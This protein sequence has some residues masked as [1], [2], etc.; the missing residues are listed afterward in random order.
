MKS[1]FKDLI[2]VFAMFSTLWLIFGCASTADL[3]NIYIDMVL[4]FDLSI[5]GKGNL[6]TEIIVP[7]DY[8][9]YHGYI[10]RSFYQEVEQQGWS[11]PKVW[12]DDGSN[13]HLSQ[14]IYFNDISE[15]ED[16]DASFYIYEKPLKRN[17]KLSFNIE[18]KDFFGKNQDN[19]MSLTVK[20]FMPGDI[21]ENNASSTGYGSVTWNINPQSN[22]SMNFYVNSEAVFYITP[23][24][25]L[26]INEDGSGTLKGKVVGE[27]SLSTGADRWA[28]DDFEKVVS[29]L[30]QK[31]IPL[32]NKV[33]FNRGDDGVRDY[34][35]MILDFSDMQELDS[36]LRDL[37]EEDIM[38]FRSYPSL[39]SNSY[40]LNL[41]LSDTLIPYGDAL[42][43]S[44]IRINPPG[45]VVESNSDSNIP[46]NRTWIFED[47]RE[48]NV[49]L[50]YEVKKSLN[51]FD[52][53]LL[54]MTA[55]GKR[56][57]SVKFFLSLLLPLIMTLFTVVTVVKRRR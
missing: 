10:E 43:K 38:T 37:A 51:P 40:S 19:I 36:F 41:K 55:D 53:E 8:S 15:L 50:K 39:T 12:L 3:G 2:L 25:Y 26:N 21:S 33:T 7:S 17:F 56:D 6:K 35:E 23:V 1:R 57:R 5:N 28:K 22:D 47:G 18:P 32:S 20:A 31:I 14:K 24:F 42:N 29:G 9:G 16:I 44:V 45:E 4:T 11:E 34:F 46:G 49:S 27:E 54:T 48:S 13:L 30:K 52:F